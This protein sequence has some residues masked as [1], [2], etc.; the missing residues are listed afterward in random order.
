MNTK[1]GSI[2]LI[3]DKYN[4]LIGFHVFSVKVFI[5]LKIKCV[6]GLSEF[7]YKWFNILHRI[8]FDI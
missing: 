1:I 4:D 6:H 2:F 8:F 7:G 5:V 3:K